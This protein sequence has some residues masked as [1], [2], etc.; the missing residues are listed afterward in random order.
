MT[1][2]KYV[3]ELVGSITYRV[4]SVTPPT[5]PEPFSIDAASGG[6]N[7]TI[8]LDREEISQYD[9]LIEVCQYQ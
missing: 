7:T 4:Q 8:E 3:S 1:T 6:I 9:I 5:T 2:L